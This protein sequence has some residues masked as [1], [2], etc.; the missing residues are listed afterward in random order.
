MRFCTD[1]RR[2]GFVLMEAVVSLVI[3]GLVAIA[4]LGATAAQVRTAAKAEQLLTARALAEERI[5]TLRSLD[6]Y[7]LSDVPDSLRAGV[8]P[9]PFDAFSWRAEV[10]TVDGEYDLFTIGVVVTTGAEAFPVR[11]LAH[12]PR[13]LEA[14]QLQ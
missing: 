12:E 6:Y 10:A 9:H 1:S 5:A 4:L 14:A 2:T 8:F 11:T 13:P 7:G 3:I